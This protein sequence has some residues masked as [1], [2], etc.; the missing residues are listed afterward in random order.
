MKKKAF[1]LGAGPTG[2]VTAWKLLENDWDVTIIEKN[3]ISGG[4]CRSWN[5]KNFIIDTGPHIFHTPDKFL[6]NFWLKHF[7]KELIQGKFWCQNVKG[8]N[9]DEFYDYP[10]SVESLNKYDKVLKKKIKKELKKIKP[11][12]KKESKNYKEYIDSFVGP[13]LRKMFFEKYPK[14]IWGISTD[15]MTPDWAPNRIKFRKKILP[16][17]TEEFCAVGKLGTGSIY[18]NIEKKIKKLNGKIKFNETVIGL[19]QNQNKIHGIKTN[20]KFY[21]IDKESIVISTLPLNLTAK[22][23]G[24]KSSLKFRGICSVYL[25]YKKKYILPKKTH[26]LYFDS[27]RLLF[28]RVTETKKLSKYTCPKKQSYLTAEITYS[29]GDRFSKK[30]KYEVMKTVADQLHKTKIVNNKDLFH[31]DINYEPYVYPIQFSN[32]KKDVAD[33]KSFVESYENLFSIGAGGEFNYADSQ[34]LF[35]KSFDLVNSLITKYNDFTNESKN[36]ANIKLNKEVKIGNL[37]IGDKHKTYIIA[38]AGLNH[39]GSFELAKQLIDQAKLTGCNSIKF[40]SFLP[41][42]RVSKEVKS[43][44]YAEKVIGTQES[45]SELFRRLS[46]SFSTQKKIFSYARKRKLEIFSTPFDFESADF[47]EK[48][49]VSAFKIAS[50]DLNNLPLIKYVASKQKTMIL[51]TGMSKISE[52]DEAVEAVKSTG[53]KNLI[54]LHCNSSYPSTYSEMNLKFIDTLK[55]MYDIPVGLSDHTTDLLASKVGIVRGI[56]ILERHFTIDKNLEGPDHILSS[57]YKEIKEIVKFKKNYKKWSSFWSSIK[58]NKKQKN[59]VTLLLG[60][61]IKKIQPNEYITLNSQKKSLYAKKAIKKGEKFTKNNICIKGPA[62]GITPKFFDIIINKK[63]K[64]KM[65]KDQPITWNDF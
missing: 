18:K 53:N 24:K 50:A 21:K 14:K 56:N 65:L 15:K 38:E 35:H 41:N 8:K 22:F 9:F 28:N 57:D 44:K 54:L 51:S 61:G 39:N 40:Q 45:L 16:F 13:T 42:S 62:G 12:Q 6:K 11:N 58:L 48:M 5:W 27:E 52:I 49:K 31:M 30:G 1:I 17:Y 2:L 25:F 3:S 23:L 36:P 4:L 29:P 26:W 20:K 34:I 19:D 63:S 59:N 43:E 47:L 37:K 60:D 10:L 33:I 46:L 55:K 32:F 7:G 64:F